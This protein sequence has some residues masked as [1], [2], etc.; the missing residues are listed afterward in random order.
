MVSRKS[1]DSIEH[2][3]FRD[4]P[5]VLRPGDVLVINTSGTRK[6]SLPA[7]RT[8]GSEVRLHLSTRLPADLWMVGNAVNRM[9]HGRSYTRVRAR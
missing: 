1:D 4:L 2:V 6:A 9:G 8:D 5:D 3:G 7:V